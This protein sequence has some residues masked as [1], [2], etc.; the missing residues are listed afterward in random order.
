MKGLENDRKQKKIICNRNNTRR[1]NKR[2]I[3]F[4]RTTNISNINLYIWQCR[5]RWKKI[6][7][8]RRRIYLFKTRKPNQRCFGE[9]TS[10]PWR[11]RSSSINIIRNGSNHII[12]L[13][14]HKS[15]RSYPSMRHTLRMHIRIFKR[16]NKI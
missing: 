16:N 2:Y 11:S 3:R 13:A 12:N 4:I 9:K 5:T 1:R 14:I 15:R 6:C 7:P 8:R 10:S